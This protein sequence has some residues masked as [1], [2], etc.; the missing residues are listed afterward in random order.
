MNNQEKFN[1]DFLR[2]YL[3]PER[4]EQ[5][6]EGFT[7]KVMSRVNLEKKR[8]SE[9]RLIK[10][11]LVPLIYAGVIAVLIAL[12]FLIPG[13]QSDSLTAPFLK[14]LFKTGLTM[15]KLNLSSLYNF[16][17]PSVTIYV[18]ISILF[19]TIFDRALYGIFHK[20]K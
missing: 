8:P 14:I 18:T 20:T 5:A 12:S 6:P 11:S 16:S 4:I 7:S 1:E 13:E 15:P 17:L 19:L 3:S 2:E 10:K 9:E